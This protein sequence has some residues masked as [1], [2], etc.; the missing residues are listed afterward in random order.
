MEQFHSFP[1]FLGRQFGG[2]HQLVPVVPHGFERFDRI[3]PG[4]ILVPDI[5]DAFGLVDLI[6]TICGFVNLSLRT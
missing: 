5:D 3:V 4:L 1:T 6:S 2:V